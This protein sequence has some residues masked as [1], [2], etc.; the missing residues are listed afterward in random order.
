MFSQAIRYFVP[1]GVALYVPGAVYAKSVDADIK[2]KKCSP[3]DVYEDVKVKEPKVVDDCKET[4]L[5]MCIK[6]CR[7]GLAPVKSDV[8]KFTS[9]ASAFMKETCTSVKENIDYLQNKAP[10]E[11][12][13]GAIAGGTLVGVLLAIRKGIIKKIIYGTI[14]GTATYAVIYPEDAQKNA[15]IGF[16]LAKKYGCIGY[17]FIVQGGEPCKEKEAPKK[18]CPVKKNAEEKKERENMEKQA[19]K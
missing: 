17:N 5:E 12:K 11:V 10:D 19:C 1:V 13:Y 7:E 4:E 8:M 14:T 2:S 9:Q 3:A 6:A 18:N 15:K 16:A